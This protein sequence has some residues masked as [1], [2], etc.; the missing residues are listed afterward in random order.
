MNKSEVKKKELVIEKEDYFEEE[1]PFKALHFFES[2]TKNFYYIN[3]DEIEEEY[4][5]G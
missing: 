4:W 1:C 5:N 3:L 2:K